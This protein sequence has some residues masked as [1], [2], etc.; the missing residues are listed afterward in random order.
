MEINDKNLL[1]LHK[2]IYDP[3][4]KANGIITSIEITPLFFPDGMHP[5]FWYRVFI[6]RNHSESILLVD[7][8]KDKKIKFLIP[9][10][11]TMSAKEE[12]DYQERIISDLKEYF[13]DDFSDDILMYMPEEERQRQIRRLDQVFDSLQYWDQYLENKNCQEEK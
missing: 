11:L 8:I 1:L 6:N 5:G 10:N 9:F 2:L 7:D 4:I 3:R 12:K 13:G